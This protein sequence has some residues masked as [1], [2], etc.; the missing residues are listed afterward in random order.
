LPWISKSITY[1]DYVFVA[2]AIQ[3]EMRKRHII[4]CGLSVSTIFFRIIS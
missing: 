3:R 1:S 2:L 4:I